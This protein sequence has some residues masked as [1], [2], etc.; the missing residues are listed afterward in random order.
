MAANNEE[1]CAG[2]GCFLLIAL[3][4][5]TIGAVCFD[6]CL[7]GFFGVD[8]PWYADVLCGLFT[9]EVVVP[10]AV[11]LWIISWFAT[12]PLAR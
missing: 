5:L 12:L 8:I 6:Y 7:W 3:F 10:L 2:C 9:G 4:N 11:V 1:G